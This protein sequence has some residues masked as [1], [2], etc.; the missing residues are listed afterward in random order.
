[1]RL[2]GYVLKCFVVVSLLPVLSPATL[3]M[4][5]AGGPSGYFTNITPVLV[6]PNFSDFAF[7]PSPDGLTMY[8]TSFNRSN[9]PG[10][11]DN[12]VATR[13]DVESTFGNIQSLGSPVNSPQNEGVGAIS[14]D[15]KTLYFDSERPGG[16]GGIDMYQATRASIDLP[17][18]TVTN[19]G[20]GVNTDLGEGPARVSADQLTMVFSRF[21]QDVLDIWMATRSSVVEPFGNATK[22]LVT[23]YKDWTPSLSTDKLTLF[24]SDW[25]FDPPRPGSVG[26]SVDIWVS[27]RASENDPFGTPVNLNVMWPGSLVNTPAIEGFAYIS[28]DWPAYGSKLYYASNG[29]TGALVADGFQAT[30]VPEPGSLLLI[31]VGLAAFTVG[32]QR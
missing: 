18:D 29:L 11:Q 1:M 27:T 9:P 2:F 14:P 4:A 13:S 28:S 31:L 7:S 15:G 3:P 23:P 10:N 22:I 30:W 32:R 6:D 17:F 20:P 26:D 25:V 16:F 8:F 19:L 24:L 12:F 5:E 21:E